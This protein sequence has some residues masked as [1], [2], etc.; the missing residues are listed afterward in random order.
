MASYKLSK[1]VKK[2]VPKQRAKISGNPFVEPA[3]DIAKKKKPRSGEL[4]IKKVAKK[5]GKALTPKQYTIKLRKIRMKK[6]RERLK[7][8]NYDMSVVALERR[9]KA[10]EKTLQ[11]H[12]KARD[13]YKK[14]YQ[15]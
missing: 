15:K 2:E 4:A 5:H 9:R 7:A 14:E 11:L 6:I 3:V 8:D 13:K 1:Q 10:D 12:R